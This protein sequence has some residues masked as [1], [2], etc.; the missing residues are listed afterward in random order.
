MAITQRRIQLKE[1]L[2]NQVQP[3]TALQL[4]SR[5]G[6]NERVVRYDLDCLEDEFMREGYRLVKKPS[7]GIW[8]ETVA[9][10]RENVCL[11][12]GEYVFS[13]EER[14]KILVLLLLIK[15][16]AITIK[17]LA[18]KL[19]ISPSALF[20][21]MRSLDT[22]IA[23]YGL[24]LCSKRGLGYWIEGEE[25]KRRRAAADIWSQLAHAA[26]ALLQLLQ[27]GHYGQ[28]HMIY[29]EFDARFIQS[30]ASIS[31][32]MAEI[33]QKQG[34]H[35]YDSALNNVLI[36]IAIMLKRHRDGH[37]LTVTPDELKPIKN[38]ALY[39]ALGQLKDYLEATFAVELTEAEMTVLTIHVLGAKFSRESGPYSIGKGED[40]QYAVQIATEFIRYIEVWLGTDLDDEE[41]LSALVLHLKSA[42]YRIQYDMILRNPLLAQVRQRYA[43]I[44][45]MTKKASE[46]VEHLIKKRIPEEEV[47]FLA[48]H[49]GAAL[50]R[51]KQ[52]QA[53]PKKVAIV[54]GS[55]IGTAQLLVE[56]L[57]T[58]IPGLN[59]S[60]VYTSSQVHIIQKE[61]VDLIIT[62]IPLSGMNI[63][64]LKV[65]PILTPDELKAIEK[66]VNSMEIVTETAEMFKRRG[67]LPVLQDVL[68]TSTIRL[69]QHAEDWKEAITI[70]GNLLVE[71]D[72]VEPRYI[73]GM[74]RNVENLGPYIV[75]TPGVA[76]PHARPEEGVKRVCL[77]MVRLDKPVNFGNPTNDP[78]KL[79]FALGGVDHESHLQVLS[80]LVTL[81][82]NPEALQV[83]QEATDLEEILRVIA[84]YSQK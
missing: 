33:G 35:L 84:K 6:V 25:L 69:D 8:L 55:G 18:E 42:I 31:M 70:A 16:E 40:W 60:G 28:Y 7:V 17:Q 5:L 57:K 48:M 56:T 15:D 21:D 77:S 52:Q 1:L 37:M 46:Y 14:K 83:L 4:A 2:L 24:R 9:P 47:G 19:S 50:E 62:T 66:Q 29:D 72:A 38:H 34:F 79:V 22:D 58:N 44:Y 51:K 10:H 32:L 53:L 81:L 39:R 3:I 30:I 13:P 68:D 65:S 59:I 43:H 73:Q 64:T 45:N 11:F 78:V 75:I 82:D 67:E 49:I 41:L 71:T 76:M 23:R 20:E 27:P 61:Q 12:N 54:C 74:I 26:G 36:H 80:Q 63:P